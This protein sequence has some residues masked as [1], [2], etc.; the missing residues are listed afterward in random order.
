M[1]SERVIDMFLL[2]RAHEALGDAILLRAAFV[3]HA[4]VDA[5]C[6]QAVGMQPGCIL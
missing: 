3:R 4:D 5:V 6:E 2:E 1:C